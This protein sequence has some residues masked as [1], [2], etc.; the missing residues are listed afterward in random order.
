[1]VVE[2]RRIHLSRHCKGVDAQRIRSN[3]RWRDLENLGADGP[4]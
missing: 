3:E 4:A 2:S 1:M